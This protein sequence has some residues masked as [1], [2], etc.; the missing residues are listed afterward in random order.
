L[1]Q[2]REEFL[3]EAQQLISLV[4]TTLVSISLSFTQEELP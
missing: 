1:Q 3:F 4:K 2:L